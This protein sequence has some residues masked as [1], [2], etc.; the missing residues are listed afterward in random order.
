MRSLDSEGENHL[1]IMKTEVT[2]A[3]QRLAAL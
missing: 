2:G 1:M 3:P